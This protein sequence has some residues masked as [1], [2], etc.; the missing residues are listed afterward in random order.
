[1]AEKSIIISFLDPIIEANIR[2]QASLRLELDEDAN[3]G[4]T[5]FS[6][7]D[8]VYFRFISSSSEAYT[9]EV[10]DGSAIK[11]ASNIHYPIEDEEVQFANTNEGSLT[12]LPV[13]GVTTSWLGVSGGTPVFDGSTVNL[14]N[15]VTAILNCTYS[16][17]GD[18]L[19]L[20][21]FTVSKVLIVVIQGE[22]QASYAL[23][24]V[25]V[26]TG[27]TPY[28]LQV[29]DFCDDGILSGVAVYL[30]GSYKGLSNSEGLVSLGDLSPGSS[31]T[32]RMVKTGYISS[33]VDALNN[34]SFEAN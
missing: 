27:P 13:V 25:D 16:T 17:K 6:V 4:A 34:D 26:S 11:S 5:S 31:Y 33:D 28:Q 30:N 10:S 18:R 3:N 21:G 12:Y 22:N 20:S 23:S 32:L 8:D 29:K 14:N 7:G 1:M 15:D 9:I 24:I 2:I 19:K